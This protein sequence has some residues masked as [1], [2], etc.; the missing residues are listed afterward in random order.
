MVDRLERAELLIRV[1]S[2]LDGRVTHARLTRKGERRLAKS[3]ELLPA[4]VEANFGAH[5]SD[6]QVLKLGGALEAVL[7][8]HARW[9]GQLAQLRGYRPERT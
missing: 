9:E 7:T 3:R 6:D 1:P 2:E 4:W 5:L 8:G